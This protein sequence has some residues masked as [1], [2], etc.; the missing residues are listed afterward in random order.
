MEALARG[1][2]ANSRPASDEGAPTQN[3][4][5]KDLNPAFT[6]ERKEDGA[7][8]P[9][10]SSSAANHHHPITSASNVVESKGHLLLVMQTW[11]I[12]DKLPPED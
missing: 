4:K 1:N 3:T 7:A 8:A 10:T 5:T 12:L 6:A 2:A 11:R 9:P